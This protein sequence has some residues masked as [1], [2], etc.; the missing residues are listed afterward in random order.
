[1]SQIPLTAPEL[2]PFENAAS[3]EWLSTNGIGGFAS[4]TAAGA[5]MRRYHALLVAALPQ[6]YGRMTVFSKVDETLTVDGATYDL[7]SNRY[8][9]G[10][11]YPDG[12][13]HVAEFT[14]DPVPTWTYRLPNGATLLKRV[15][16]ARG[17]NTVHVTYTLR[18]APADASLTLTP[19]VAWKGYHAQMHAWPE[20]PHE[21]GAEAGGWAVRPTPDAPL[22]RLLAPGARWARAGWWHE[23]IVHDREAERGQ[24]ASEDLYCPAVATLTL[25]P[26]Q[27]VALTGTIE[28]EEPTEATPVLAQIVARQEGLLRQAGVAD[29]DAAGRALVL[30]ADPFLAAPPGAEQRSTIL[31]GYPWFT[32]WGRD[33]MIALPGLCLCT[34]RTGEARDILLSFAR[35]VR[36]GMIPNRFPDAGEAP[37]YNTVDATLWFVHACGRYVAAAADRAF[38]KEALPVLEQIIEAHVAGT[39]FGICVDP[40]DGLLRAGEPGTQLTW[41][42]AKIGDWVVTP[43]V[44]KPVEVCALWVN[45]LRTVAHLKGAR[46]GKKY[47]DMADHAEA[48]FREKFVRPD[49]RGLLD[50]LHDDGSVDHSVRP[51]QVIAAA[52]PYSPLTVE[53]ARSVVSVATRELLTPYGLR[54]LSPSDPHYR[55]TYSGDMRSR[56][57]AYHQGTVWP[58]LLGPYVDA[59]RRVDPAADA[60]AVIA[61]LV[62]T[63]LREYGVGGIAEVFDG[64]APHRPG[65]CPWQAWSVA[66]LLQARSAAAA[67]SAGAAT[68]PKPRAR[69]KTPTEESAQK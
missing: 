67:A 17:R 38:Q 39:R 6:P 8:P 30:A 13:R 65:G 29:G 34:G 33:T 68:K 20:F 15:Y 46:G 47:N 22:L 43:R 31:A 44:G 36:G 28:D 14:A 61:P 12:W 54:T 19:L 49:G 23:Q 1:M 62:E 37:D 35:H 66:A 26:G 4:G 50:V 40:E 51:N 64:D 7:S 53:Q 63:H 2:T 57:S 27:T 10:V 69:R 56:D 58:W 60:G 55:P 25:R 32:D 18:E 16:L 21:E 9:N 42:D 5:S 45:A 11:V 52:L 24:D 41:M 59:L 3:R 48:S